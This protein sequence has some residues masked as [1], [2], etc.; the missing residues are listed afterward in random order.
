MNNS[1][2][3]VIYGG[4]IILLL[5]LLFP[6]YLFD[7]SGFSSD[8]GYLFVFADKEAEGL[9]DVNLNRLFIQYLFVVTIC[10]GLILTLKDKK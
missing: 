10:Y 2:K 5:M 4:I 9:I 3:K 6:P 1:Q 8:K 7:G